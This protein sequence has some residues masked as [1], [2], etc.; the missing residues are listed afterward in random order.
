MPLSKPHR[1]AYPESEASN[2]SKATGIE[3]AD[4]TARPSPSS[5]KPVFF[6][7][8]VHTNHAQAPRVNNRVRRVTSWLKLLFDLPLRLW[9]HDHRRHA[10]V[11][12]FARK[13]SKKR[14]W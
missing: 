8:V 13:P 1:D 14:H 10:T 3:P 6:Q 11:L 4:A 7:D 5:S 2:R 12:H 9:R